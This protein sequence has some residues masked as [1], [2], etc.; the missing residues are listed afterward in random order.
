MVMVRQTISSNRVF[1]A[2]WG[3]DMC[4][5]SPN[6]VSSHGIVPNSCHLTWDRLMMMVRSTQFRCWAR[7]ADPNA[8]A[9]REEY[10]APPKAA[11]VMVVY[12]FD[13]CLRRTR[14]RGSCGC[15]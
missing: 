11:I 8:E 2:P 14:G 4:R 1:Q 6:D 9:A 15:G 10:A 13:R 12:L 7:H 3:N 5:G